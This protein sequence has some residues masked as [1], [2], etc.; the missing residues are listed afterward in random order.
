MPLYAFTC[1]ACGPFELRRAVAEAA[2][3]GDC[4]AC[5]AVG[6]RLFTPPGVARMQ[7]PMRAARTREERSAHAPDVVGAPAGR[8]LPWRHNHAH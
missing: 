6:R 2:A 4:P 5:G 7:A 1:A 3:A 8:P